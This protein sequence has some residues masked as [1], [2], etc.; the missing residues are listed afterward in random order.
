MREADQEIAPQD[1]EGSLF[2]PGFTDMGAL[3]AAELALWLDRGETYRGLTDEQRI[4]VQ[5]HMNSE[6]ERLNGAAVTQRLVIV[7]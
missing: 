6:R 3:E 5:A 7:K 2:L 1:P 4:K